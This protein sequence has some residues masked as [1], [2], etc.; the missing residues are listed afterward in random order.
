MTTTQIK[1]RGYHEDRF[2]HVN[3]ARYLELLEEGRWAY[4]EEH[5]I[6]AA[7][8]RDHRV[9]PV[10]VRLTISYRRP[11]SAGDVLIVITRLAK[12]GSRKVILAQEVRFAP[13]G[14]VCVKAEVTAVFLDESTGRPV[15]LGEPFFRAWPELR[16]SPTDCSGPRSPAAWHREASPGASTHP[17][18]FQK[19]P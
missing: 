4:L 2:G 1:I 5:G 9:F 15:S 10:V 3:N 16:R 14:E 18:D 13:S 12:S 6:D 17:Q 11:A 8:F 19:T 7:F